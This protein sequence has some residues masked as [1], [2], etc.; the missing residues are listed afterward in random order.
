MHYIKWKYDR[1]IAKK[2]I[3]GYNLHMKRILFVF[4]LAIGLFVLIL[5]NTK[6]EEKLIEMKVE[7]LDNVIFDR[8][9]CRE[10]ICDYTMSKD[11]LTI[12]LKNISQK[13]VE[14][15]PMKVYYTKKDGKYC[16][17]KISAFERD[18]DYL[19]KLYTTKGFYSIACLEKFPFINN[20]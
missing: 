9:Q 11:K 5:Y 20:E 19:S 15:T 12:K 8:D 7:I 14:K 4:L 3:L 18:L 16:I 17:L 13:I 10:S 2:L 6:K 1:K